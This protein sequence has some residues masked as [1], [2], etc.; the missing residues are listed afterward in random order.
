M[1]ETTY[2]GDLK[3]GDMFMEQNDGCP[4][5]EAIRFDRQPYGRS[6]LGRN[7]ITGED[8][9]LAL[10]DG[11]YKTVWLL[12]RVGSGTGDARPGEVECQ[13]WQP[14]RDPCDLKHHGKHVEELG[15]LVAALGRAICQGMDAVD[16]KTGKPNRANIQDESADVEAQLILGRLRFGYDRNVMDRR[17][18]RKIAQQRVWHGALDQ[19]QACESCGHVQ[20]TPCD[21][22]PK[23]PAKPSH[24]A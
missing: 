15:E 22:T 10:D 2:I 23:N 8:H 12:K 21:E 1:K 9:W 20:G 5:L 19:P 24:E 7:L 13:P 18:E 17:I 11:L 4:V 14:M 6:L 16:P 3:P